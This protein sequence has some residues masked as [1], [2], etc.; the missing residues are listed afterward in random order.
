MEGKEKEREEMI[1]DR[2]GRE[3]GKGKVKGWV[4]KKVKKK[5]TEWEE[6]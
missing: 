4:I 1:K 5:S 3:G 2:Y 6:Q